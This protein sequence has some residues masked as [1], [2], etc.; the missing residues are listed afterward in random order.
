MQDFTLINL[1]GRLK[2]AKLTKS[3]RILNNCFCK[4]SHVPF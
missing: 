2:L 1:G 4:L 3:R